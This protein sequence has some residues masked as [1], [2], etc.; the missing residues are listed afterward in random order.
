MNI[1]IIFLLI[2]L[3]AVNV[4]ADEQIS[5]KGLTLEQA[6]IRVLENHPKLKIAD[7]EAQAM[8]ARMRKALLIPADRVNISL[9]DFA[10]IDSVSGVRGVEATFSLSRTLEL[11]NKAA[12]R[13]AVVDRETLLLS[14]QKDIDRLDLLTETARRFLHVAADQ[15]RLFIAQ[16]AIDLIK[17]T[18][19]TV[20]KRIETGKTPTVERQ[21]V[22]IDLANYELDLDH[23]RHEMES[24]RLSLATLWND[25][26]SNFDVVEGDIFRLDVLPDFIELEKLL[27]RN[28]NL[29][30]HIRAEDLARA[31]IRLAQSKSKPDVDLSAGLRYLAEGDDVAFMFSASIPLGTA[32]R[33]QHGI[34]EAEALSRIA[35]LNLEQQRMELYA[36]LFE[37]HQEMKHAIDAVVTLRKKIIPAAEEMLVAYKKGYQ[38][39]RYSLLE[40]IQIQQLL[41]SMRSRAVDMAVNYHNYRIEID[42]LTAAQLSQR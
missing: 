20:E 30:R 2:C 37:I 7:Y 32:G 10:G 29:I 26:R 19:K 11:G 15:E 38:F 22:A 23:K 25:K 1:K 42:R 21:R 14:N 13:G 28:P 9:E 12:R 31:R 24:S 35:P 3:C 8:A 18:E 17:L 34:A 16:D 41:L 40:L 27:D 4:F 36:T 33:A 39:G 6:I 5:Q